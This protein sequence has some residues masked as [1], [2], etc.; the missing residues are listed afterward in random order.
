MDN[1]QLALFNNFENV[2]DSHSSRNKIKNRN[3]LDDALRQAEIRFPSD[4]VTH[5]AN[6]THV[7]L[8]QGNVSLSWEQLDLNFGFGYTEEDNVESNDLDF[9]KDL[10]AL[11][12]LGK[13][14]RLI[15][16][17]KLIQELSNKLLAAGLGAWELRTVFDRVGDELGI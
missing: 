14:D 6:V 7:A 8:E 16:V 15:L 10:S 11:L 17:R 5:V 1:M 3:K 4:E 12:P 9:S 13:M 2:S